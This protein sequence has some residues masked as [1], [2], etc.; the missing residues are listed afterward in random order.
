MPVVKIPK[1]FQKENNLL[2]AVLAC[3]NTTDGDN[4]DEGPIFPCDTARH[5]ITAKASFQTVYKLCTVKGVHSKHFYYHH[6]LFLLLLG[7]VSPPPP[8]PPATLLWFP[9]PITPIWV[10]GQFIIGWIT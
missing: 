8:L 4:F 7:V 6:V 9:E 10:S 1:Q 5:R 2:A 3:G